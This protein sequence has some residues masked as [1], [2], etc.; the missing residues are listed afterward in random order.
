M[1]R[2][3]TPKTNGGNEAVSNPG[4]TVSNSVA[5][6]AVAASAVETEAKKA[7][8]AKNAVAKSAPKLEAVPRSSNVVPFNLEDEIRKVAYLLSER[9][10]FVPGYESEDWLAA[11]DEV[12]QRY[13]QQH[14]A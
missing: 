2:A 5:A 13:R 11:E 9:R 3:K 12:R 7:R 1:A 10:G 4:A 6:E 8:A 14:S